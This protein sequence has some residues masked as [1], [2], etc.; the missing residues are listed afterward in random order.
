MPFMFSYGMNTNRALMYLRCKNATVVGPGILWGYRLHFRYHCDVTHT[1]SLRNKVNGLIWELDGDDLH[2]IDDVEGY[3]EYYT[4]QE[5][6]VQLTDEAQRVINSNYWMCWVYKMNNQCGVEA[7][8][9]QYLNAVLQGYEENNIPKNQLY[10][11]LEFC[12]V[13]GDHYG[14]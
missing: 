2:L 11:A 1:S 10:E 3:P 7:P 12:N 14:S 13:S 8:S 5:L 9:D 4:R 6:Y